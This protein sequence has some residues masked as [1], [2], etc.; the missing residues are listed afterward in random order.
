MLFDSFPSVSAIHSLR[1]INHSVYW[2]DNPANAAVRPAPREALFGVAEADLLIIGAGFTGLWAAQLAQRQHPDWR[3]VIVEGGRVANAAT[4]R[5]GG[6]VS[7]SLTHGFANGMAR[8]PSEM[9]QLLSMGKQ[10]LASIAEFI[11]EHQLDCD[12]MLAG[13]IDVAVEE[14]QVGDLRETALEMA[15]LGLNIQFLTENQV[16]ARVNSPTYRAGLFDPDVALVDPARLAW[17][18]SAHVTNSSVTIFENTPVSKL[19]NQG[20]HVQAVTPHGAVNAARVIL[21]TNA[22]PPLLKRIQNFTIPV[23]DYVLVSEPLSADQRASIG[24]QGREGLSDS[25]NQFHYYR[26]TSDGRILWGGFDASYYS[27]QPFAR[28][29]EQSPGSHLRLA[30]HF[31]QTF[32][33]LEGLRFEYAWGGAIDTCSR[34]TAFWGMA[35]QNKT[36]YVSGYTGLGVGASRFAAQVMLDLLEGERN[37]RTELAMVRSKPIPFPPEPLRSIGIAITQNAL[38]RADSNQGKRN[39]WLRALDGLGMGFDS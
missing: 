27:K 14:Y 37:E 34:F 8:W 13:E 9:P 20:V 38:Q 31:F 30:R 11:T 6:F 15:D 36:A 25:G 16:R 5:N 1:D 29:N 21:A 35:H 17:E 7:A 19:H 26:T 10:N 24:W 22:F 39:L 23:Y 32:P 33:Q 12:F 3:I 18:L 28:A 4:G 2:L